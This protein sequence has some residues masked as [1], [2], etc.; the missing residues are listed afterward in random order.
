MN[1]TRAIT[2]HYCPTCKVGIDAAFSKPLACPRCGQSRKRIRS[3]EWSIRVTEPASGWAA[4]IPV[5]LESVFEH[6]VKTQ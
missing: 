6:R 5:E 2:I 3:Y 1:S 4:E